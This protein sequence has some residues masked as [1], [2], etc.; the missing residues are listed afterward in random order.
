LDLIHHEMG[1]VPRSWSGVAV[2]PP[3]TLHSSMCSVPVL[4]IRTNRDAP[5]NLCPPEHSE[6]TDIKRYSELE[7]SL[8][9]DHNA[10]SE[11]RFLSKPARATADEA[12]MPTKY[13]HTLLF[14]CPDCHLP[15]AIS[16]FSSRGKMEAIGAES[17]P[18][19][20]RY[21]GTI[22]QMIAATAK[23]HY[24]DEWPP[25]NCGS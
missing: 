1:W 5:C 20:C 9:S 4:S 17:L 15:V 18:V 7:R 3:R 21:C 2:A 11:R 10:G 14:A 12:E 6:Y 13:V 19:K 8:Y 16:H 25:A 24:L 22:S 23:R